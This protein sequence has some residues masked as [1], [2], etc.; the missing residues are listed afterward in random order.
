[1]CHELKP[2]QLRAQQKLVYVDLFV[3]AVEIVRAKATV[4]LLPR[5]PT[6]LHLLFRLAHDY[7]GN[8]SLDPFALELFGT[9]RV[10]NR[11]TTKVLKKLVEFLNEDILR[12]FI[13]SAYS[14][15]RNGPQSP[16][17]GGGPPKRRR[18]GDR[19]RTSKRKGGGAPTTLGPRKGSSTTGEQAKRSITAPKG[20]C[21]FFLASNCRDGDQ[22]SFTHNKNQKSKWRKKCKSAGIPLG[23]LLQKRRPRRKPGRAGP[24]P[25][26]F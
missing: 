26:G 21:W 2:N 8:G 18:T 10:D 17:G 5:V 14:G 11:K 19:R 6:L 16:K 7:F 22:C 1:M 4:A 15:K 3:R 9:D 24:A 13:K 12:Y 20:A 25:Q 23:N